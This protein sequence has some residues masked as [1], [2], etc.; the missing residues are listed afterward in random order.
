MNLPLDAQ[1]VSQGFEFRAGRPFAGNERVQEQPCRGQLGDGLD[2]HVEALALHQPAGGA[3]HESG[4]DQLRLQVVLAEGSAGRFIK[5]EARG[6]DAIRHHGDPPSGRHLPV[7]EHAGILGV[8][9]DHGV[10]PF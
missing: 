6:V 4:L 10:G 2:E 7:V 8:Q 5:A 9:G 3:D 1:P